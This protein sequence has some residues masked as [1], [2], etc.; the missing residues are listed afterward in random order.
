MTKR[1]WSHSITRHS[2]DIDFQRG[3]FSLSSPKKIADSLKQSTQAHSRPAVA[4]FRSAMSM[5]D[6]YIS[7]SGKHLPKGQLAVLE[8]AKAELRKGIDRE[9]QH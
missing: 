8:K 9:S 3:L 1:R 4:P 6:F 7:H 2:D 5:L